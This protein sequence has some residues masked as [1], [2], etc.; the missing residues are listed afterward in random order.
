MFTPKE[1]E[2]LS[3]RAKGETQAEIARALG[4]TQP[5]V[6]KFE[7]NARRKLLDAQATIDLARKTGATTIDEPTGRRVTYRGGAT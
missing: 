4:M 5:A 1:F 7:R 3:R 6:S 2:I